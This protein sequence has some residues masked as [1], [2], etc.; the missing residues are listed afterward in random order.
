MRRATV[1]ERLRQALVAGSL[2][3][4]LLGGTSCSGEPCGSRI[5]VLD[6]VPGDGGLD[7]TICGY[8]VIGCNLVTINSGGHYG[9]GLSCNLANV[10]P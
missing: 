8:P 10:C 6:A 2:A 5:V 4:G 9:T 7:C 3:A 1:S